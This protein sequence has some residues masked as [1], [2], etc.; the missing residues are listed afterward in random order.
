MA[1]AKKQSKRQK[2]S[3]KYNIQKKVRE[4]RRKM[5]KEAKTKGG[6][7]RR[8][9]RRDLG[10]PNSFPFK[11]EVVATVLSRKK[12]K[13]ERL[14]REREEKRQQRLQQQ[15]EQEAAAAAAA[16]ALQAKGQQGDAAAMQ[17]MADAAAAATK[18]FEARAAAPEGPTDADLGL[19][20]IASSLSVSSSSKQQH[21]AALQR[22]QQQQLRQLLAAADVIINVLDARLPLAYRCAGLERWALREGKKVI[23]LLN[24]V[25]LL[26]AAAVGA[27][28]QQLRR[29]TVFPVLAFKCSSSSS[30]RGARR[31]AADP[32]HAT[33]K[34]KRSSSH[35][36][37][38]QPLLRLLSSIGHAA[39][40]P[41]RCGEAAAAAAGDTVTVEEGDSEACSSSSNSSR[42]SSSGSKAFMTV[43][44][45]GYPNVGK[46]SVINALTRSASS[47]AVAALPG[48]TKVLKYIKLD[49]RT[50]LIDSPGVL[51]SPPAREEDTAKILPHPLS[52]A[53]QQQQQQQQRP[54]VASGSLLLQSLVPVPQIPNPEAV[55]EALIAVSS[56]HTLQLLY[57][58][59]AFTSPRE[60]LQAIASR[61]GKLLKGGVADV[62]ATAKIFLQEWQEGKV[63]YYSLPSGFKDKGSIRVVSVAE[64]AED[65][66]AALQQ[67]LL[68]KQ[69]VSLG[70]P[71]ADPAPAPAAGDAAA[72]AAAA[73]ETLQ[74]VHGEMRLMF[75][76]VTATKR[77]RHQERCEAEASER[78]E[79]VTLRQRRRKLEKKRRRREETPG[80]AMEEDAA[81]Q[82]ETGDPSEEL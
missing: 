48:S 55:A 19:Q 21:V 64:G 79:H 4:H 15:Q 75:G 72:A 61:R 62:S 10:I 37:G 26:P 2:L 27:W 40:N 53:T 23:L 13:E 46:S 17:K 66:V 34:L 44:V 80:A 35:A 28:L 1:K 45:V 33:E 68:E 20:S 71:P 41:S 57:R 29:S 14:L 31:V 22:Q 60:A 54:L 42:G 69:L 73:E 77:Q 38:V 18:A 67:E 30:K 25:D 58:L 59:P 16:A 39:A 5:R 8:K 12:E 3:R 9:L 32:L 51:F 49:S 78:M 6:P 74:P 52:L 50:Q 24:K 65:E 7:V 81:A 70:V 63:P 11:A 36:L 47:A 56:V 82:G 76:D 43:G